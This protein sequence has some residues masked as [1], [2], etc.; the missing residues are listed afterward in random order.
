MQGIHEHFHEL[1]IRLQ[2]Q[3]PIVYLYIAITNGVVLQEDNDPLYVFAPLKSR[4]RIFLEFTR[5]GKPPTV[6]RKFYS[7]EGILTI[8]P[9][10][11]CSSNI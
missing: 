11:D 9:T 10:S 4:E 8:R 5:V 3:E 7:S 1:S 6:V 2:K